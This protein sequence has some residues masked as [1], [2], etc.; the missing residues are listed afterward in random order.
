MKSLIAAL[1]IGLSFAAHVVRADSPDQFE[2]QLAS[3]PTA[4]LAGSR[5]KALEL[6]KKRASKFRLLPGITLS[7]GVMLELVG[8]KDHFVRHRNYVL[9]THERPKRSGLFD[10]DATFKKVIVDGDK[11]RFESSNYSGF[12]ITARPDG[13]MLIERNPDRARSTFILKKD[14]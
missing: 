3:D 12:F 14:K 5:D 10:A 8:A 11:V 13:G 2:I 6:T 1:L 7:D 4:T 9:W